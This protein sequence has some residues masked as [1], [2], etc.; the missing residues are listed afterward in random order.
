MADAPRL[1]LEL[2]GE[3][4]FGADLPAAGTL[5]IGR[6]R[7]RASFVVDGQ[8]IDDAHCAI[9]RTKE[10]EFAVK[11]LGSRYGTL[12]NGQRVTSARLRAGDQLVLG[13]RRL[14]VRPARA[15]EA[16]A[17]P[18]APVAKGGDGRPGDVPPKIGGYR[19]ERLI[20]RGA[21]GAV[22]LAVQES[23]RRPVA[24]KVLSPKLAAD[25]DFVRR[26]QAEARAA[27]ALSHPNV[28]V[29][30]DVG[31][32]HGAHYLS[33]EFMAGGSLEQKLVAS[34][35]LPWRSVLAVLT[36]AASGLSYAEAR[37]IVHRDIKP[38]NLMYSGT[39]TVKIAD[40]GLATTLEQQENGA[41]AEGG[42]KVFGTPHFIS[43]EQARGEPVD[44]RSD[45]YS[46]G[47][48]AY[49]L[50]SGRTPFEGGST[51]DILRALQTE[52][53]RPLHEL[54]ADLP[55]ELEAL[56][57]RLMARSSLERPPTA[58][59]LRRECERLRLV[60]EH[61]PSLV[62]RQASRAQLWIGV[63][64]LLVV[65]ATAGAWYLFGREPQSSA[66]GRDQAALETERGTR[67]LAGDGGF[68][69]EPAEPP[70]PAVDEERA[71]REREREAAFELR[72]L[73]PMLSVAERIAALRDIAARFP[74]TE[75]AAS[76][77]QELLS[78]EA[79]ERARAAPASSTAEAVE[80]LRTELLR[81]A[82]WPPAEGELPRPCDSLRAIADFAPPLDLQDE[83]QPVL[84]ALQHEVSSGSAERLRAA[85]AEAE[86][87]ASAGSFDELRALLP[88]VIRGLEGLE[89]LSPLSIDAARLAELQALAEEARGRLAGLD[90]EEQLF[91]EGA[92]LER[93]L[94][95][96]RSLGSGSGLAEELRALELEAIQARLGRLA[97]ELGERA[98]PRALA[99]S[100]SGARA[101]LETLAREFASGGWRR[102]TVS[103]PRTK[104]PREVRDFTPEGLVFA[105]DEQLALVP[106]RELQG[107]PEWWNQLFQGRLER[108]WSPEEKRGIAALLRLSGAARAAELA[109]AMLDPRGRGLLQPA[110]L[111]ALRAAFAP[112]DAWLA[113]N[114]DPELAQESTAAGLL[115][116]ALGAAQEKR[117][118]H[119]A[120]ALERCL[121]ECGDTLTVGLL[122]DGGDWR[123]RPPAAAPAPGPAPEQPAAP[124][125]ETPRDGER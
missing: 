72:S 48:T 42:R 71:L 97:P 125:Q 41:T 124:P 53:P 36:D 70:A 90:L 30:Y 43:P 75:A 95:L 81:R 8:G 77:Q 21:M 65:V 57:E 73:A 40:L 31:E 45:L 123:E 54:V 4:G 101:A 91:R 98:L 67:E 96:G 63:A 108:E 111:Q 2:L 44:H 50:L 14:E 56:I 68:F 29:V 121:A 55:A 104:R 12:L 82:G 13:S 119:S 52:S 117:W 58:E 74:G 33:M 120:S 86:S 107:D 89:T 22:Y 27:A 64:L 28:V 20:G 62:G 114:G 24:L 76:A 47:A 51:R 35:P 99:G 85:L 17:A 122:S 102:K 6:S 19:V 34:G 80:E 18:G 5:V 3:D 84:V 115:A 9:G 7:E 23:L 103:D 105:D 37:G 59:A 83:F 16:P 106:W 94:T 79:G 11:D 113:E 109:Q 69:D 25:G 66:G 61:G 110:E 32:A 60:A 116:D 100:V 46:L 1:R 118:S 112:T 10:G 26:F 92:E 49:R 38:A 78:L 88:A 87:R 39:G 15:A 93:S